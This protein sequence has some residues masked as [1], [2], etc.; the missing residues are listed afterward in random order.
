MSSE[1]E[2]EKAPPGLRGF[3]LHVLPALAYVALIFYGGSIGTPEVPRVS[4]LPVDKILH[5]LAFGGMQVL[6]LRAVRWERPVLALSRQIAV[7]AVISIAAGGLLEI[8]Q[9]FL[10]HR[11]AELFDFVADS[12]GVALSSLLL[13]VAF[14]RRSA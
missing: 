11:T 2:A 14:G 8:Y 12:L 13:A 3:L 5:F 1:R 4:A 6:A 9:A 7:A 10:P